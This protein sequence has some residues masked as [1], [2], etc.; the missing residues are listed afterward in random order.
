MRRTYRLALLLLGLGL[1]RGAGPRVQAQTPPSDAAPFAV[2]LLILEATGEALPGLGLELLLFQYGA[3]TEIWWAGSCVTEA[4]GT[5]LITATLPPSRAPAWYEG[6]VYV[7]TLGR[8]R[9]GWQGQEAL[10]TVQLAPDGNVPTEEAFLHPPYDT[11]PASATD[12]PLGWLPTPTDTPLPT[13]TPTASLEA[14]PPSPPPLTPTVARPLLTPT[15]PPGAASGTPWLAWL[16][17]G[18]GLLILLL[19]WLLWRLYAKK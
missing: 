6:V 14:S 15:P 16:L 18:S 13:L 5:C 8:Q 1:W 10:L 11:Q 9:V 7:S 17:G 2:R 19:G 4:D 3:N 12:V